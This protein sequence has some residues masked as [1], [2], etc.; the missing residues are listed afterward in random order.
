MK[1]ADKDQIITY[2]QTQLRESSSRLLEYTVDSS[3]KEFKRRSMALIIDKYINNFK[4]KGS[5]PRWVAISGLRGVGKT[6][7][8]A[9]IFI[10]LK[11]DKDHKLYISLDESKNILN[12][13]L[14]Q[15]LQVYEELLGCSFESLKSEVYI[16]ID[17]VHYD[18]SWNIVL[19]TIYDK[20]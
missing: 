13:D 12:A 4:L 17:E 6:T 11:C 20:S 16:F 18:P 3:G 9:Q 15:L 7:I 14:W 5:E 2:L 8:L 10:N 1:D 19:K